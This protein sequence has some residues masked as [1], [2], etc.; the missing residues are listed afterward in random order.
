MRLRVEFFSGRI[1]YKSLFSHHGLSSEEFVMQSLKH[2]RRT[3][4]HECDE[5]EKFTPT[6][7]SP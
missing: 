5:T 2:A 4:D 7:V 1:T 3:M 6:H